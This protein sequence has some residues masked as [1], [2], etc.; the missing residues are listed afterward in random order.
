MRN[1]LGLFPDRPGLVF[2]YTDF[3]PDEIHAGVRRLAEALRSVRP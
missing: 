3:T 2:G 1:A